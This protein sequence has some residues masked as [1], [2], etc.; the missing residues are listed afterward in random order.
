M[1]SFLL[2]GVNC[3]NAEGHFLLVLI[4][5]I[6]LFLSAASGA[7]AHLGLLDHASVRRYGLNEFALFIQPGIGLDLLADGL[8]VLDQMV[9]M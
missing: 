2:F 3:G 4:I 9:L 5:R 6:G 8:L 7:A 1:I